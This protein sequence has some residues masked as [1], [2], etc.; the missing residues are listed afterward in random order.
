MSLYACIVDVAIMTFMEDNLW[1]ALFLYE[2]IYIF[3][4]VLFFLF[5]F[6]FLWQYL[7]MW[8]SHY[9][10]KM[11]SILNL[12]IACLMVGWLEEYQ[13]LIEVE[14]ISWEIGGLQLKLIW[15]QGE[16]HQ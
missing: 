16:T 10:P 9:A 15:L 1:C 13:Q 6:L 3:K 8:L 11:A 12:V 7:C 14:Y 5:F 2:M 4:F